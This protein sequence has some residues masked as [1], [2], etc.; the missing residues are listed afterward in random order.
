MTYVVILVFIL[1]VGFFYVLN[2]VILATKKKGA[3]KV[4]VALLS[5]EMVFISYVFSI[6][7]D[8]YSIAVFFAYLVPLILIILDAKNYW[9]ITRH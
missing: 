9:A 3:W 1:L 4:A 8:Y 7:F 5:L 2:G 6:Y